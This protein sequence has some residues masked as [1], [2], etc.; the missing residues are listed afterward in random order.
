MFL[1]TANRYA[2]AHTVHGVTFVLV[3]GSASYATP[4]SRAS[5]S[6]ARRTLPRTVAHSIADDDDATPS[7]E[8]HPRKGSSGESNGAFLPRLAS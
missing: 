2:A 7:T 8:R 1:L 6:P 5:M 4:A 3:R